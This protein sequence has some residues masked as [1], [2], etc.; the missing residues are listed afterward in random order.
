MSTYPFAMN[1]ALFIGGLYFTFNGQNLAFSTTILITNAFIA[2][3]MLALPLAAS[4]G[5][6]LA[7]WLCFTLLFI[8]GL[9]SGILQ[10][11]CYSYNAK[12]PQEYIAVFLT[13]HGLAGVCSNALRMLSLCIWPVSE[14]L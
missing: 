10:A 4:L 13:S 7:Y 6:T 3:T 5:D 9:F 2:L 11:A 12:L 1:S 8:Y 14:S